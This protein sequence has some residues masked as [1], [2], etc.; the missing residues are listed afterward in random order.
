M[1][2]KWTCSLFAVFLLSVSG[3]AGPE[4]PCPESPQPEAPSTPATDSGPSG[5]SVSTTPG[6]SPST[7][8]DQLGSTFNPDAKGSSGGGGDLF[9]PKDITLGKNPLDH[10]LVRQYLKSVDKLM[11]WKQEDIE[12]RKSLQREQ[13]QKLARMEERVVSKKEYIH[14]ILLR[15]WGRAMDRQLKSRRGIDEINKSFQEN[16]DRKQALEAQKKEAYRDR[17]RWDKIYEELNDLDK[18]ES[19]LQQ[20]MMD[21]VQER[22]RADAGMKSADQSLKWGFESL[23]EQVGEYEQYKRDVGTIPTDIQNASIP[24]LNK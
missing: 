6:S 24:G 8:G 20:D 18:Q 4:V 9:D 13:R 10:N 14:T 17:D 3:F 19:K 1:K 15:D 22:D 23:K 16:Y 11:E 21:A 2:T 5:N 7:V 12:R